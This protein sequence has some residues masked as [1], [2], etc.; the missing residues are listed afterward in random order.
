MTTRKTKLK[1]KIKKKDVWDT[2]WQPHF[3]EKEL[4]K[5]ESENRRRAL[6]PFGDD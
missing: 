3:S 1:K 6:S 4:E 5:I 2:I